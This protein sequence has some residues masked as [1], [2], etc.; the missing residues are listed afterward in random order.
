MSD[1]Q[2]MIRDLPKDQRP[3]ERLHA[4][5]PNSLSDTELMAIL[6]RF[7]TEGESVIRVAERLLSTFV[8]LKGLA[9]ASADDLATIKGIGPAKAAELMAALEI[10]KR[11]AAF[12][13]APRPTIRCPQDVYQLIGTEMRYL[14]QEQFRT[15]S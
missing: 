11:L 2:P 14:S 5:G 7:G 9:Q 3:R 1:Y 8:S 10:G 15:L 4:F 12:T 6:L 13:D